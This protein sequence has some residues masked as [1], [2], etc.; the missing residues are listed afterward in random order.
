MLGSESQLMTEDTLGKMVQLI[1]RWH[2][3]LSREYT[4]YC[5]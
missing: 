3:R 4:K 1:M 5:N 2:C